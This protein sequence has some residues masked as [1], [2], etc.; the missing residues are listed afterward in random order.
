[1]SYRDEMKALREV[2]ASL[3]SF[4]NAEQLN[5]WDRQRKARAQKRQDK[6]DQANAGIKNPNSMSVW[7]DEHGDLKDDA[8]P[9]QWA[10]NLAKAKHSPSGMRMFN[11]FSKQF[12][13]KRKPQRVKRSDTMKLLLEENGIVVAEDGSVAGYDGFKFLSN[14][15]IETADDDRISAVQFVRDYC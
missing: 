10:I 14:G 2:N 15:R 6:R 7:Y 9:P 4:P 5:R 1:M 12:V 8:N 3:A 13:G 11:S